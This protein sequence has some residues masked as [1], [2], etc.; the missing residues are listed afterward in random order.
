M[1]RLTAVGTDPVPPLALAVSAQWSVVAVAA[2]VAA[3]RAVCA[4][5]AAAALRE[6]LPSR[7]EEGLR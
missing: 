6:P 5:V 4:G 3:G 2:G 1:V 7:P